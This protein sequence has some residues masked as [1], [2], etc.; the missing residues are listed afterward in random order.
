[1]NPGAPKNDCIARD[2]I[3][4]VVPPELQSLLAKR[5][6][7]SQITYPLSRRASIKDILE[8]LGVPHC[9]VGAIL[10]RSDGRSI[11]FQYM[12]KPQDGFILHPFNK[13]TPLF[14]PT[15]LR[16]RPLRR[17]AFMV[18]STVLR[19][20][21][22]LRMAGFDTTRTPDDNLSAIG[23]S[24]DNESRILLSRN[25]E[26]LKCK[27]VTFGQLIRST[28]YQE[29]LREVFDRYA[30]AEPPAPFSRCVHCN[31]RLRDVAKDH[32]LDQLEPLTKRYFQTFKQCPGCQK[33]YWPG[34]HLERMRTI[35]ALCR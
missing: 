15:K 20:A 17:L 8:S 6:R 26:L 35:L 9:E 23:E 22:Y 28:G 33:I 18:D 19:L 4:F 13:S 1:M 10:H 30:P 31:D 14:T 11:S 2:L 29:Q 16:P 21:R 32:I 12:P 7:H 25:R 24:A 34:T 5:T 3:E 27:T